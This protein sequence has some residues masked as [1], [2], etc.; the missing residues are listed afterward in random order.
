MQD[1]GTLGGNFSFGG[2]INDR[3]QAGGVSLTAPDPQTGQSAQHVFVWER[4]YLTDL[5]LG[6]SFAEGPTFNNR[7]QAVGH[8]RLPGEREDH[9]FLWDGKNNR[10]PW[11]TR[12]HVLTSYGDQRKRKYFRCGQD[13]KRRTASRRTLAGSGDRRSGHRPRRRL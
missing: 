3:G 13:Y 6:G 7:G 2:D 9:A 10:R 8:F 12:E 4:G 5:T 1:L 11:D